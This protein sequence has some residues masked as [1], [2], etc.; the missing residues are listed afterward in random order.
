MHIRPTRLIIYKTIDEY[1]VAGRDGKIILVVN[2]IIYVHQC[3]N[4]DRS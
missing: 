4:V 1:L 2:I 3:S